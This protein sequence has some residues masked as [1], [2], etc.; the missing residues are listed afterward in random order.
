MARG[1]PMFSVPCPVFRNVKTNSLITEIYLWSIS[2]QLEALFS[3]F[4][5]LV[6]HFS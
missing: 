3:F 6:S 5:K 4:F 1:D 2:F